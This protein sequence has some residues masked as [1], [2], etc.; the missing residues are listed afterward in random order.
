MTAVV[1][2]VTKMHAAGEA[3]EQQLPFQLAVIELPNDM[4]TTVRIV[5]PPVK[6]GDRVNP[7][8]ANP[9]CWRLAPLSC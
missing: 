6:I 1:Y 3:F 7:D 8:P 4:R 5:G 9:G 2:S